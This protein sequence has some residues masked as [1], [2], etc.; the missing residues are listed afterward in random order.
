[1]ELE[2]LRTTVDRL[3]TELDAAESELEA[4]REYVPDGD[5]EITPEEAMAGTNLFVR[6]ERKGG[7]TLEDAHSGDA[8][9]EAVNDNIRLEHHTEFDDDGAV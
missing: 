9:R 2:E 8:G 4:A 3:E 1:A 6:Y 7:P 5:H